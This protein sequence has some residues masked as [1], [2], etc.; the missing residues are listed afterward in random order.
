MCLCPLKSR[1]LAS[2]PAEEGKLLHN[3]ILLLVCL[4]SLKLRRLA[5]P[6]AEEGRLLHDTLLQLTVPSV[7]HRVERW[8]AAQIALHCAGACLEAIL[9]HT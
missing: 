7:V 9:W 5:L 1:R 8:A 3:I 4:C 2:P 6:S